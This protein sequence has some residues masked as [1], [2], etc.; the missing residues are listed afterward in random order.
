MDWFERLTGFREESYAETRSKL[1]VDGD[2]LTSS[3]NGRS[4]GIGRLELS[5]LHELRARVGSCGGPAGRLRVAI[6]QGDVR[7]MHRPPEYVGALR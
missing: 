5:G 3:V 7:P 6:V 2:R 4:Y 1:S